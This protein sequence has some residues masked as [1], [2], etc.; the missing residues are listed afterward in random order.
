MK[1]LLRLILTAPLCAAGLT[2]G[3][4]TAGIVAPGICS[5]ATYAHTLALVVEHAD[6]ATIRLC[7]G[8]DNATI[9]GDQAL[10]AS[11]LETGE[12]S[13]SASLGTAVCQID[14]EPATYP[15]TCWTTTSPYWAL[16]VSRTGGAWSQ[17]Q[18]GVS[19]L[20]LAAGDAEGFRYEPQTGA[21]D[22]PPSP[23]GTCA[24]AAAAAS[25]GAKAPSG[26]RATAS[27]SAGRLVPATAQPAP[28]SS[29]EVTRASGPT[30]AA[31]P[32]ARAVAVHA[33]AA[34]AGA[35]NAGLVA[36]VAAAGA[37]LG[38]LGARLLAA[39]RSPPPR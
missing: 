17:A 1:R 20:T 4:A 10:H 36:A 19:T 33:A 22:P 37:M 2:A 11:G 21:V 32:S 30:T 5:A 25:T 27:P 12:I 8:F 28:A 29:P 31:R 35:L 7:I 23:A 34:P 15:P 3:G 9:T 16:F 13:E 38:L 18:A 6:G 26:G 24:S 14:S 39:R